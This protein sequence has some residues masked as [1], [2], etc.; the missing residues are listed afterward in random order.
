MFASGLRRIYQKDV[1]V[2]QGG[3]LLTLNYFT[4]C[5]LG[6]YPGIFLFTGSLRRIVEFRKIHEI[7]KNK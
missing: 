1:K 4:L 6:E 3:A 7:K 2:Y 5:H